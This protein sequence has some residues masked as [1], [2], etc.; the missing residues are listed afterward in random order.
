[1]LPPVASRFLA[2]E[3]AAAA[4]ERARV[5]NERDIGA[6]LNLLGEH[7]RDRRAVAA[8]T[9]AYRQLI[10]DIAA[11]DLRAC[12]SMKP[13]QLG[14]D[15][16]AACFREHYGAVVERA[17][18]RDV[19]VWLDMEDHTT[20]A[21][22]LA[23][24]TEQAR[25]Y[26]GLGVCVQANLR[27]SEEDLEALAGLPGKV[28]LVKGAYEPP[29]GI[30]VDADAVNE[31][32]RELLEYM[33]AEFDDGVA[34]GSHDPALIAHAADCHERYG[35]P[36]ELQF[37]MGVRERAQTDLADYHDVWQYVPY[38]RQWLEYFSRRLRERRDTL[39][40]ALRALLGR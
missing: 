32:T 28:R 20:T 35:T 27:R 12:L 37:L 7:Y 21:A 26:D 25:T 13:T 16:S 18:D 34:L 24:Y 15:I 1:M 9:R 17:A 3:T 36:Y 11:S 30:A 6:I 40:F 14:L 33:F 38:G 10:D 39:R 31:Q 4:L 19:F 5:L 22:T 2:G 8:D 23:A 29:A